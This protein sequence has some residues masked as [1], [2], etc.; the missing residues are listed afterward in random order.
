MKSVLG[1]L[2]LV[3]F[4]L[5][6][7][8]V[9]AQTVV[10]GYVTDA[11]TG[12]PL[13]FVGIGIKGTAAGTT[14]DF[15]GYYEV[16]TTEPGVKQISFSY[17]GY[18]TLYIDIKADTSQVINVNLK[19]GGQVLNE[20][21]IS[22]KHKYRNK[23][24]PAV[25]LIRLVIDNK[26]KNRISGYKRLQFE[27]Y[28]KVQLSVSNAQ[29]FLKKDPFLRKYSFV[30]DNV[31]TASVAGSALLPIY[32]EENF[33][34]Q[35]R[36]GEP[37]R[38]KS[39]ITATKRI[40]FDDR[41]I[42]NESLSKYLSYLYQ[43]ADI[44]AN[45][46]SII[47]NLFLSPIADVAPTF[48]KFYITDTVVEQGDK[49]IELSF[50][51][52]NNTDFLFQGKLYISLD[53]NYA[54][55][56][57][58]LGVNKDVNLN[59][60][61]ELNLTMNFR[62]ELSGKYRPV[63]NKM[64]I[65]YGLNTAKKGIYGERTVRVMNFNTQ[66]DFAD[67]VFDGDLKTRTATALE[68]PDSF[69]RQE[70]P[71]NL[72][73]V[74]QKAYNNMDSLNEIPS[75]KRLMYTISTFTSGYSD[76]GPVEIGPVFSF[77]SFNPVEGFRLRAG[78]RTTEQFSKLFFADAYAAYGLRDQQWKYYLSGS[79]ALNRKSIFTFPQHFI[80]LSTHKEVSVPGIDL[81]FV[82]VESGLL[83]FRRGVNDKFFYNNVHKIEYVV[84]LKNHMRFWLQYKNHEITPAGILTF[85][86]S[87]V[88]AAQVPSVTTSEFALEWRWAPFEQF[89]QRKLYRK[90]IPNK[91]PIITANFKAGLKDFLN[92]GYD[93]Q[94]ISAQIYKRFFLSPVGLANVTIGGGY[95]FGQVPY[96]FL[97]IARANQTYS[98]MQQ[99]YNL[100]NFLEFVSDRYVSVN[101]DY[102]LYG[103]LFNKVPLFKKLNLREVVGFKMLYGGVRPENRPELNDN[104]FRLPLSQNGERTTFSL[105]QQ[106][107]MEMNVGIENLFNLFRVDLIRR[108]NYLDHPHVTKWGVRA[109]LNFD[110]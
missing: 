72:S 16:T 15:S 65:H 6:Y 64:L 35:Y 96:P 18:L 93:Y 46:I 94:Q 107:Y 80:R 86:T 71:I 52:R 108:I 8:S 81:Q 88:D 22:T 13:P 41:F 63:A 90:N 47:S 50:Y 14:S 110:F 66:A 40:K 45:N 58:D 37:V 29:N 54:V 34:T 101:I 11:A 51:P 19:E 23:N 43:D 89:Y 68:T 55:Q 3:L 75:F 4:V 104:L 99:S 12:E 24:N 9:C 70:R 31:D 95:L 42:N 100:M 87:G 78:G 10:K 57:A 39:L 74:E 25:D 97:D 91:Y 106:P 1:I 61:K 62:K 36:T 73:A 109:S 85:E 30:M 5:G 82:Q 20:V 76:I 105:E 21:V 59:W 26:E 48:Y 27:E 49:L 44:Y 2:I 60:V 83:S 84:E 32:I 33:V 98:F 79:I 17:I 28:E 53:G 38:K 67:S 92:G 69:W 103:F 7:S 102:H 77:F 56:K